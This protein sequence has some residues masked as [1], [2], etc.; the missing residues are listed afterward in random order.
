V[1]FV[2]DFVFFPEREK[3]IEVLILVRDIFGSFGLGINYQKLKIT[4]TSEVLA[5]S[6]FFRDQPLYDGEVQ[7]PVFSCSIYCN[8][9]NYSIH[10]I[11]FCSNSMQLRI[12]PSL[13][14]KTKKN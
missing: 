3:E 2:D 10:L 8:L 1:R 4:G 14:I 12:S 7:S 6:D 13:V 5:E 11:A 9:E